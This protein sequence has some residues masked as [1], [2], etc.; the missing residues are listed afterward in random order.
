MQCNYLF[1][2]YFIKIRNILTGCYNVHVELE[3]IKA[4]QE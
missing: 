3:K 4:I 1:F 2:L